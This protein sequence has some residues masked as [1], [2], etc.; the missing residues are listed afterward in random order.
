MK[1]PDRVRIPPL[2]T[3]LRQLPANELLSFKNIESAYRSEYSPH[4]TKTAALVRRLSEGRWKIDY[5]D[6]IETELFDRNIPKGSSGDDGLALAF[7]AITSGKNPLEQ[8]SMYREKAETQYYDALH[9]L[10][11]WQAAKKTKPKLFLVKDSGIR[12][13]AG[14]PAQT[15]LDK[16]TDG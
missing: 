5:A 1:E 10:T 12:T 7:L 3:D 4:N 11:E 16:G 8:I 14:A 6:R 15:P 13:E 2:Y 9:K